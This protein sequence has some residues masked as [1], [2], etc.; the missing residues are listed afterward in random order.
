MMALLAAV[1][2]SR[3]SDNFA[4]MSAM[5][6]VMRSMGR[7]GPMTPVEPSST[8]F[9]GMPRVLEAKAAVCP[10]MPRP[11]FPVAALA[12]PAFTTTAW[13]DFS[14]YTTSMSHS[15]G[16]ALTLFVVN[17]P[18][19]VQGTALVIIAMSVRFLYLMPA[20]QHAALKPFGVVTPPVIF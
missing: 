14:L 9:S 16:A 18:A 20:A 5:P 1:P 3:V 4:A 12:M 8:R 2:A 11:V 19:T 15:T 6:A 7:L 13:A 10:Q 17:V